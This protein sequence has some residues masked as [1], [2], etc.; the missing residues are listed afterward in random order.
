M[1]S[2][3][4]SSFQKFI[5]LILI[6]VLVVF[7]VGFAAEGWQPPAE[8]IPND[9]DENNNSNN[10]EEN[11]DQQ[12][13]DTGNN[14]NSGNNNEG[15]NETPDE[16]EIPTYISVATGL[17]ITEGEFNAT[18]MGIVVD[19]MMPMYGISDSDIS[20]EFPIEDGSS[21]MLCYT[22]CEDVMWKIGCLKATRDY[23]SSMSS[24][25]GG[26][27]VS[28]GKDDIV[29]YDAWETDKLELDL[30]AHADCFYVENTLYVYTSESLIESAKEREKETLNS[31]GYANMP[32]SFADKDSSVGKN[33]ATVV[34]IPYS[35]QNETTLYYNELTMQ[36]L[37]YKSG[38]RKMDMLTGKNVAFTNV[39][40]L[41][42]NAT[43]FENSSGSQLVIDT[44]SGGKGYY[45]SSG[46]LAEFNWSTDRSGN[47]IFKNLM[48]EKL[49]VNRGNSYIAFFKASNSSKI[50]FS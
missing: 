33:E 12:I 27:V 41:F 8:D 13:P 25:F 10:N 26:I 24:F 44:V 19:P 43:T 42:S 36:Y 28:Y 2:F 37:Y 50:T 34:N 31:V 49:S 15:S 6:V 40:V 16:P 46:K 18:P 39:F 35:L 20:I 22:T 11:N 17:Q 48:G 21:R 4:L 5:C 23:I 29:A 9:G 32:Y 47:L 1:N 45:I 3:K 14:D 7:A 38:N 30:S